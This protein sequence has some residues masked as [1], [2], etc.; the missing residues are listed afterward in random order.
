M[1]DEDHRSTNNVDDGEKDEVN[2]V[3]QELCEKAK[4]KTG[5]NF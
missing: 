1:T 4:K 2:E 5:F 3:H